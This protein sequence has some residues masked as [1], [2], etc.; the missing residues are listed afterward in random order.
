M[1]DAVDL[2]VEDARTISVADAAD[3]L[4]LGGLRRAG[5][6]ERIGPCPACGG[7]DR[8]GI[9][10]SRNVWN[11]RG[12]GGG[13]D[14]I[15]MAAHVLGLDVTRRDDF[16]EAC[17]AV[18][19]QAVPDGQG[20]SEERR[21][22]RLAQLVERRRLAEERADRREA[23]T[24]AYREGERQKA[25]DKWR[26]GLPGLPTV[27]AYLRARLGGHELP[28]L[29]FLRGVER[30]F[31]WHGE[32]EGGPVLLHT[33]VA[34]V[35]PF[36][37]P[38]GLVIG[39]HLTWLDQHGPKGRPLLVDGGGERLPTKKMRG[40]KKGGL[41][42]LVGWTMVGGTI[43]PD[44]ARRRLV[45]GE[46]IE[47]TVA[48][49]VVEMEGDPELFARSLYAAAGD[50]G[51]LAGPADPKSSFTHPSLKR[52]DKNGKPRA[53][54]V[55]G[56]DPKPDQ[57]LDDAFQP[58]A[59]VDEILLLGDADSEPVAT[60]AAMMRARARLGGKGRAWIAWPPAGKDFADVLCGV[61]EAA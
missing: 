15:G 35:A 4:G 23:E 52:P 14:A 32:G 6:A 19:G 1:S 3:R 31:Y 58:P 38:A 50:L 55:Q 17:S 2:F 30:E 18:T 44:L 12:G 9:N 34:M 39:C 42:P 16:L 20:E 21:Q 49:A 56:H 57:A 48:A 25:R 27:D 54:R 60:M 22:L 5:T 26:Q 37:D 33:G 13:H 7:T 46:G 43:L 51:N 8:F 61:S 10:T 53:V 28:P 24:N 36:V 11:C 41:I 29:P 40:T 59:H 47:N 45:V